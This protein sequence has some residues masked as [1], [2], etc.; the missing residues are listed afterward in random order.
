LKWILTGAWVVSIAA[1]VGIGYRLAAPTAGPQSTTRSDVV[2]GASDALSDR[3]VLSRTFGLVEALRKVDESNIDR[4]VAVFEAQRV[5]VTAFEVR[6]FMSSW[7]RFDPEGAFAWADGWPGPWRETLSN[8]AVHAW[9][10]RDPRGAA[11]AFA[12]LDPARQEELRAS[13]IGGWAQSGDT[14]GL[15]D[16]LFSYPASPE[17]SRFI[18]VLLSELIQLDDGPQRIR[19]WAEGVPRDAP[20]QARATAFLTAGGA[21]A[22]NDPRNALA[23]YEAHQEFDYAQPAL[24][25]IAR[26]WVEFHDAPDLFEWLVVLPPG[27]ARDDAVTAGFSRWWSQSPAAARSWLSKSP[28]NP[29]LDPAVA[30]MA[31]EIS[32]T[33]PARAIVWA[34]GIHD[35][36][37]RRRAV[38]PILRLWID[39]DR[40][41]ARAWMRKHSVPTEVQRELLN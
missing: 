39:E 32:R 11:A 37:T 5:G 16:H 36:E 9:A 24:R 41:A 33:S 13:L 4:V 29:P 35:P 28:L 14:A 20:H 30:V 27:K 10:Y 17:R 38:V 22:Q 31:R 6:L 15:T 1:A 26:R 21:L 25:T 18:G 8:A 2:A 40:R 19:R 34:D 23:L 12:E 7:C 3:D